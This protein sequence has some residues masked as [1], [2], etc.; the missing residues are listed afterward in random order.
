VQSCWCKWLRCWLRIPTLH[1]NAHSAQLWLGMLCICALPH[2]MAT[3]ALGNYCLLTLLSVCA[4]PHALFPRLGATRS[5]HVCWKRGF[6]RA[7]V[8]H[9]CICLPWP[10]TH[11]TRTETHTQ[12]CNPSL[13][14][15]GND[16]VRETTQTMCMHHVLQGN[17]L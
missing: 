4:L 8:H 16:S 15:G 6:I 5:R 7:C 1:G 17:L 10:L 14:S 3:R 11:N 2:C 13:L 12:T 9:T